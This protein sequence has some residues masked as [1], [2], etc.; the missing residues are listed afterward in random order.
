M[1]QLHEANSSGNVASEELKSAEKAALSFV[2]AFKY[3]SLYP[4]GHTF[5]QNYLHRL[6]EDLEEFLKNRKSLRLDIERYTFFYKGQP[7]FKSSTDENNPAYLLTR[8][9]IMFL[10]FTRNIQ[11]IEITA[12]F[13]ILNTHRN[14][15]EEV[16]GDIATSLWH[17]PFN[18][19]HYEAADIF[20]MEA[21]DF[22]LSMFNPL[23]AHEYSPENDQ[24]T[25]DGIDNKNRENLGNG[26]QTKM[27][28]GDHDGTDQHYAGFY[29]NETETGMDSQDGPDSSAPG[30]LSIAKENDLAELTTHEMLVLESYVLNEKERDIANDTVDVLLIILSTVTDQI[31]F[32]TILDL[33]EFEFFDSLAR[34]E[35]HLANKIC[36]NLNNISNVVA[37]KKPWAMTLINIF[38]SALAQEERYDQLPMIKE[39]YYFA[40]DPEHLK[41]LLSV[42]DILPAEIIFTLAVLAERTSPD[43]LRQRNEL[44]ESIEKKA[45]LAP[46]YLLKILEKSDDDTCLF[47][48]SII[49]GMDR[50]EA[51]PIYLRLAHHPFSSVRRRGIDGLFQCN[52]SPSPNDLVHL[53]GDEDAQIRQKVL[54]YLET[55]GGSSPEETI[56]KYLQS[57]DAQHIEPLHVLECYRILSRC[58]SDSSIEFLREVLLG[59][60]I[61]SVFSKMHM[62]H[63][64]GAAY[65]LLRSGR[66]DAR[67]IVQR[68][69]DSVR[70]DV[71][72]ACQ[73]VLDHS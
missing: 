71:R 52:G 17:I 64:K 6:L 20:A 38:L 47:L 27:Q 14:P 29:G 66:K 40:P 70:P 15:L 35:Y 13:D 5:S 19:I 21:I 43:N 7:L 54:S 46:K 25:S 69:A 31:E 32:A 28:F 61:T 72:H 49:E 4:K 50:A 37:S 30:L 57:G 62:I 44:L 36:K 10:E 33:L 63:K 73:K 34:K 42:F 16:D 48:F 68:G 8:D 3:Y 12:L 9:R 45:R 65:A 18:N 55:P 1:S 23:P 2:A 22:E 51:S 58:L 11:L 53:L 39:G 24:E 56:I 67:E 41:Y 26:R 59:S 60:K